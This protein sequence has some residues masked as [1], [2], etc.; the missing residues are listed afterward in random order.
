LTF[1]A[2]ISALQFLVKELAAPDSKLRAYILQT[3]QNAT[4]TPTEPTGLPSTTKASGLTTQQAGDVVKE[5]LDQLAA[6]HLVRRHESGGGES[7]YTIT[8][9]GVREAEK[10]G[11]KGGSRLVERL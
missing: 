11:Q 5:A 8:A 4:G 9:D 7:V 10:S 1:I 6:Q 2:A 3:L